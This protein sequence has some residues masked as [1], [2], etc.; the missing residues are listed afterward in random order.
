GVFN[1]DRPKSRR[2]LTVYTILLAGLGAA[3]FFLALGGSGSASG[4]FALFVLGWVAYSWIANI[5][6]SRE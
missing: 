2:F 5:V 1:T 4:L 3:S 6:I